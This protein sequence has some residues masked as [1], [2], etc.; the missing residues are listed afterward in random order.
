MGR[1]LVA[2]LLALLVLLPL[3]VS[4]LEVGAASPP[5]VR[6][7]P[8][9]VP[10]RFVW[11]EGSLE[12]VLWLAPLGPADGT[13]VEL[14]N[15]DGNLS[16]DPP[17]LV[18]AEAPAI[19]I[20]LTGGLTTNA[21]LSGRYRLWQ[22][23]VDPSDPGFAPLT[24][25]ADLS[26]YQTNPFVLGALTEA[27][28]WRVL[29][30]LPVGSVIP[31]GETID[32][33]AVYLGGALV[34]ALGT[35]VGS[36]VLAD[37]N[38]SSQ[39]ARWR[40]L[41]SIEPLGQSPVLVPTLGSLDP[42]PAPAER[43]PFHLLQSIPSSGSTSPVAL[44]DGSSA[45]A[46]VVEAGGSVDVALVAT[47]TLDRL[48]PLPS[49]GVAPPQTLHA[50]WAWAAHGRQVLTLASGTTSA[51]PSDQFVLVPAASAPGSL[52]LPGTEPIL[53]A[54]PTGV[55]SGG[56]VAGSQLL[57]TIEVLVPF[58]Q[59]E[60]APT[61]HSVAQLDVL[62]WLR[63]PTSRIELRPA[64][65]EGST[66]VLPADAPS[67]V[68]TPPTV[69]GWW[70]GNALLLIDLGAAG[71]PG[72]GASASMTPW[73]A[74]SAL[75][76]ASNLA[77]ANLPIV[78]SAMRSSEPDDPYLPLCSGPEV[79]SLGP[80]Y[81]PQQ[82]DDADDLTAL[83]SDPTTRL[84]DP[85]AVFGC[86]VLAE[87]SIDPPTT[88]VI[89]RLVA[90]DTH[91]PL[92]GMGAIGAVPVTSS[93]GTLAAIVNSSIVALRYQPSDSRYGELDTTIVVNRTREPFRIDVSTNR[94]PSTVPVVVRFGPVTDERGLPL[95]GVEVTLFGPDNG[96]AVGR[97]DASGIALL[98]VTRSWTADSVGYRLRAME[99]QDQSGSMTLTVEGSM[100]GT[101]PPMRNLESGEPLDIR[102]MVIGASILVLVIIISTA[103]LMSPPERPPR[104]RNAAG[105]KSSTLN[106]E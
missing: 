84:R 30:P 38:V 39:A 67:S 78:P 94:S 31:A 3:S 1:T 83:Q 51:A 65:P 15:A 58:D 53:A 68:H 32:T 89:V 17:L 34:P 91:Q 27:D 92:A 93:N 82:A 8:L 40:L 24:D 69:R 9:G 96:T 90:S 16:F 95:S 99:R 18:V 26:T 35:T 76:F 100:T 7:P 86:P 37:G 44:H 61:V 85:T 45:Q 48:E 49:M 55:G 60:T 72:A 63:R 59:E 62:G 2:C 20:A 42:L 101:L 106:E 29:F 87:R 25:L 103:I 14:I 79:V 104:R 71:T 64:V 13:V 98:S 4:Y 50:Q 43:T 80:T 28:S 21:S 47:L 12:R 56:A 41:Q 66:V 74:L 33:T 75:R 36:E 57:R 46:A 22:L 77:W 81:V 97:T 54:L 102:F 6:E 73:P 10:V 52:P 5:H 11:T 70:E 23:P 19:S 88:H 105:R